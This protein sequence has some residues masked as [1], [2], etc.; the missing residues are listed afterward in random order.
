MD[1][2][3]PDVEVF[4]NADHHAPEADVEREPTSS[5][6]TLIG[7][8]CLKY[9]LSERAMTA[10]LELLRLNLDV[11]GINNI[12]ECLSSV[13]TATQTFAVCRNC[14]ADLG[15]GDCFDHW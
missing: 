9:A 10:L 15:I 6:C 5:P 7:I 2:P 11:S 13:D 4:N 14:H 8:F 12:S 1:I 3:G